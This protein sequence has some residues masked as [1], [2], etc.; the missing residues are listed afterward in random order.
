[1]TD[2]GIALRQLRYELIGAALALAAGAYRA[3]AA[4]WNGIDASAKA[5]V[6]R[7]RQPEKCHS[8]GHSCGQ[9]VTA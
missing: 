4:D 2:R 8:C 7:L 6:D 9:E 1:M 5:L 3:E